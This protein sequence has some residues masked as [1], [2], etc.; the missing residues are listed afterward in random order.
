MQ[1]ALGVDIGGTKISVTLGNSCGKILAKETLPIRTGKKALLGIREMVGALHRLQSQLTKGR[2][3]SGIGIGIPGPLDPEKGVVE[4]SPHL[5]GWEK[6]PLKR[7]LEREFKIPVFMTN[8]ANAAAWG[9]KV[10]G[11][12]K[13]AKN[14]AYVTVSTGIGSGLVVNGRLLL[15]ASFGAG[16][17]GHTIVVPKGAKCGCGQR[18]CLEAYASGTAIAHFVRDA[19]KKGRKSKIRQCLSRPEKVSAEVVALFARKRDALALEAFRRAGYY[20]GVGL[21]NLINLLNPERILLG[22]GVMKSWRYLWPEMTA[23]L[24]HHAWPALC[25]ACRIERASLGKE[26]GDLGALALVFHQE[27]LDGRQEVVR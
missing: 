22:G 8:D 2:R 9:E 27:A 1:Y 10:F 4:R 18:G 26:V 17:I 15:G 25:R 7:H 16:E 13:G 23:S 19:L 14:F 12:G 3:L 6:F 20:L 24:R 11:R 5:R 21:A